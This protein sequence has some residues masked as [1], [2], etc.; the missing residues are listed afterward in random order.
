MAMNWLARPSIQMVTVDSTI[1]EKAEQ[2]VESC[3]HCHPRFQYSDK[4]EMGHPRNYGL[5]TAAEISVDAHA[6]RID[7]SM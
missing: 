2:Q 4:P 1:T 6:T 3:E 5:R 7:L